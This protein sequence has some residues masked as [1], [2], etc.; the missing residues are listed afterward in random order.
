MPH[1]TLV[2]GFLGFGRFHENPSAELARTCG[3]AFELIEV[4]YAAAD[5]FV[6]TLPAREFDRLVM[7]GVDGRVTQPRLECVARNHLRGEPDVRGI[8]R[9]GAI[10]PAAPDRLCATLW[11][12]NDPMP[13]PDCSFSDDAGGY[14]CNYLLF[15]AVQVCSNSTAK[16]VGF[17]HVPPVDVMPIMRQRAILMNLL[18]RLRD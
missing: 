4:S 8:V 16:R 12:A 17:I 15:R 3:R 9:A 7:L 13:H 1:R 10:D 18:E 2:T 11:Q 5:A 14:L 6:A